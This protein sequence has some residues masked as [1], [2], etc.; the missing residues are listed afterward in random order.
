MI[1]I[2]ICCT[3]DY[4]AHNP[5]TYAIW[6]MIAAIAEGSVFVVFS[7][8]VLEQFG[9]AIGPMVYSRICLC[10]PISNTSQALIMFFLSGKIDNRIIFY[11]FAG[12]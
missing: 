12:L 1:N 7:A 9:K 6:V 8:E 5:V 10:I 4:A 11:I 3:L 2:V